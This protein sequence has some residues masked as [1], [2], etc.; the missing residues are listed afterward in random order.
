ML[1]KISSIPTTVRQGLEVVQDLPHRASSLS[2]S[3]LSQ[4]FGGCRT[5]GYVCS[6]STPCCSGHTCRYTSRLNNYLCYKCGPGT[7]YA[8]S[9]TTP[10]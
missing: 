9:G 2:E 6:N 7:P 1:D 10:H 8:C 4:V 5:E 3:I